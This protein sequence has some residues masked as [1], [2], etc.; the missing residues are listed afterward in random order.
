MNI[1]PINA[2]KDNYIWVVEQDSQVVVVDPGEAKGVLDYLY[3]E[4]KSLSAILLTHNHDD[5]TGGV[6]QIL[7][8]YP[9]TPV[10]GPAE[11]QPLSQYVLKEGD[12]FKLFGRTVTVLDTPG[13]TEGHISYLIDEALFCGD[14][15]FSA[16]TGRV[17]TGDY[18]AQFLSLQKFKQLDNIVRV[19]P[20]HEYTETNLRFAQSIE[21][22]NQHVLVALD[23]VRALRKTGKPTLPSTIGRE[24]KI[25]L[26]LQAETLEQFIKLRQAR[27]D[28]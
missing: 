21:P 11:T 19:Y 16:G 28:F 27:D 5:H 25:N 2:F 15:L 3:N 13:H 1:H 20:A 17:F 8:E 4:Q 9:N 14:S 22:A 6:E 12:S 26:L 18:Q 23:E 24:K 10:H 7:A